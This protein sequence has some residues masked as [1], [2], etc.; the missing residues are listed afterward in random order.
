MKSSTVASPTTTSTG[1]RASLAVALIAF[2]PA[3]VIA[4][5]VVVSVVVLVGIIIVFFKRQKRKKHNGHS[6]TSTANLRLATDANSGHNIN[7]A[8]FV[9]HVRTRYDVVLI[10]AQVSIRLK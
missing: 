9:F 6:V 4:L 5:G 10:D 2:V 3:V 8:Y 7:G 1:E